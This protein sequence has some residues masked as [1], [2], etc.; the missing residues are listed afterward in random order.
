MHHLNSLASTVGVRYSLQLMYII[1][2]FG[3]RQPICASPMEGD[4]Y[5]TG[6]V[7]CNIHPDPGPYLI[8]NVFEVASGQLD[9][10]PY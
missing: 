10:V 8:F 2:C 6:T 4:G 3:L 9:P 7:Q 1:Q 5:T